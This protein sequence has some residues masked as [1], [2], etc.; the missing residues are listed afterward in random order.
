MRCRR[1]SV[2]T[3]RNLVRPVWFIGV[4]RWAICYQACRGL[5]CGLVEAEVVMLR[6]RSEWRIQCGGRLSSLEGIFRD[7]VVLG[8]ARR[9]RENRRHGGD[10]QILEH[11]AAKNDFLAEGVFWERVVLTFPSQREARHPSL[12][13]DRGDRVDAGGVSACAD[14][15]VDVSE[16]AVK[17]HRID[18]RCKV[19]HPE[20]S[21]N[22][23]ELLKFF[24]DGCMVVQHD[25]DTNAVVSIM[26]I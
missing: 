5:D 24:V 16:L 11:R 9:R 25:A 2:R 12:A 26:P 7:V 8:A 22:L 17:T 13:A 1:T 23:A 19:D 10:R 3:H 21:G 20:R 6:P 18:I 15:P 4:F 14:D